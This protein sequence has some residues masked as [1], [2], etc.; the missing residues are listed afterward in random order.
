MVEII[1][2]WINETTGPQTIEPGLN[3]PDLLN[4]STIFITTN[5]IDRNL[6][7][8]VPIGQVRY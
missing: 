7:W 8:A 3:I 5:M 4:P 2:V 1:R 6:K